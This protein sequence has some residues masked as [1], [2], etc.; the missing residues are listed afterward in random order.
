[1]AW[2]WSSAVPGVRRVAVTTRGRH[3][4]FRSA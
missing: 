1:V 2:H 3:L 4:R